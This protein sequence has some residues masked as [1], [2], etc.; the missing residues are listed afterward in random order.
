MHKAFGRKVLL[1]L[2]VQSQQ[3]VRITRNTYHN[4]TLV[5]GHGKRNRNSV[6]QV[7]DSVYDSGRTPEFDLKRLKKAERY[8]TET[9]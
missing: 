7:K 6:I 9:S 1:R 5:P 8:I 2:Q 3:E 4:L